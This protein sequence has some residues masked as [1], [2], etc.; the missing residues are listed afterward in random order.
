MSR[1]TPLTASAVVAHL[2]KLNGE[3]ALGWRIEDDGLCKRFTFAS[4][5]ETMAFANAVAFVAHQLNHHPSL[6]ITFG[7]C[8]VQWSTHEPSGITQLDF[9]A[10]TRTDA[11]YTKSNA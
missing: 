3:Q 5:L 11:L 4:H 2:T 6:H 9:D 7:A 8:V 10:A 1:P